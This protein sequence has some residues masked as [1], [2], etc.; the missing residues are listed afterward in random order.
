LLPIAVFEH[1][2]AVLLDPYGSSGI[3]ARRTNR[4]DATFGPGPR[5]Y[6]PRKRM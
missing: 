2:L 5:R 3:T 6:W 1:V 4:G